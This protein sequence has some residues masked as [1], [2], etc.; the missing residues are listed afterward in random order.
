MQEKL[1]E[2]RQLAEERIKSVETMEDVEK[3]RVDLLGKKGDS[4]KILKGMGQLSAEERPIMGKLGNEVREMIT[5]SV[6]EK[7][8]A[9]NQ[10]KKKKVI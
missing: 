4:T 3:L 5:N 1:K 2:L 6:N 9:K 10:K 7:K 8:E